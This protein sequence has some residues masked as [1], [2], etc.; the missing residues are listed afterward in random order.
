MWD[1][2]AF[3]G[4]GLLFSLVLLRFKMS[5]H[6]LQVFRTMLQRCCCEAPEMFCG[7]RNFHYWV[8]FPKIGLFKNLDYFILIINMSLLKHN[9]IHY[10]LKTEIVS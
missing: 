7:L 2:W 6:L 10:D 3:Q 9:A 1:L 4:L 5:P 8:N